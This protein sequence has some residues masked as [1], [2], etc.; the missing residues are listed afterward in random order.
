MPTVKMLAE[1]NYQAFFRGYTPSG[2]Q[3]LWFYNEALQLATYGVDGSKQPCPEPSGE[4]YREFLG[5][6]VSSAMSKIWHLQ[7]S[8]TSE[9]YALLLQ[10]LNEQG[11]IRKMLLGGEPPMIGLE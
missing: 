7:Y 9:A 2:E 4:L 6:Q 8:M 11:E 10:R 3:E 5:T 1:A